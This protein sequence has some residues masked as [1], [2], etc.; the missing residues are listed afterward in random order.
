MMSNLQYTGI[1]PRGKKQRQ[2]ETTEVMRFYIEKI[3]NMSIF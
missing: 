3:M 2:S 1:F